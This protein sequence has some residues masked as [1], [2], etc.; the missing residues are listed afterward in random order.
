ME[1]SQSMDAISRL[2]ARFEIP[3]QGASA[4]TKLFEAMLQ[5]SMQSLPL[6]IVVCGGDCSMLPM[7]VVLEL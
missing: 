6:T 7:P 4:Q 2:V 5:Y 3:L 1:E